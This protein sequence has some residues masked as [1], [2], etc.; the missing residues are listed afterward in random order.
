MSIL[1]QKIIK[2]YLENIFFFHI[3]FQMRAYNNYKIDRHKYE[4]PRLELIL[5]LAMQ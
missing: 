1:L 4:T 3:S 2:N 5:I